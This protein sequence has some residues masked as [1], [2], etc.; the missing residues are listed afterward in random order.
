M[1]QRG[2]L[3]RSSALFSP[4]DFFC[5]DHGSQQVEVEEEV[6]E[7]EGEEGEAPWSV[8]RGDHLDPFCSTSQPKKKLSLSLLDPRQIK[9]FL[10]FWF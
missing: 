5:S 8:T 6:E 10:F 3:A 2:A 1:H 4:E 9:K 7:G